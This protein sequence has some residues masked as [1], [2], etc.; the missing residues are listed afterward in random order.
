MSFFRDKIRAGAGDFLS[1]AALVPLA[2]LTLRGAKPDAMPPVPASGAG[3][4]AAGR[5]NRA[6]SGQREFPFAKRPAR[7]R[8]GRRA[9]RLAVARG[10]APAGGFR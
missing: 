9:V 8:G 7:H 10:L 1:L 5:G 6:V 2:F 3:A 4:G